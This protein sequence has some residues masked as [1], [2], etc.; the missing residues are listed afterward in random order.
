MQVCTLLQTD[1]HTSTSPLEMEDKNKG[2]PTF[3]GSTHQK[4]QLRER[5]L[6]RLLAAH[7]K[8]NVSVVST[9]G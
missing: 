4:E 3:S 5:N 2:L 6:Q 9:C 7:G 1:N 8:N